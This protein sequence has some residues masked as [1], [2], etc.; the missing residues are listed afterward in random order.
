MALNLSM[1]IALSIWFEMPL[2]LF[3]PRLPH[4]W[5]ELQHFFQLHDFITYFRTQPYLHFWPLCW[6][7]TKNSPTQRKFD[8]GH[9]LEESGNLEK[10]NLQKKLYFLQYFVEQDTFLRSD[11]TYMVL[12]LVLVGW[13]FVHDQK[14]QSLSQCSPPTSWYIIRPN[15]WGFQRL[16]SSSKLRKLEYE[17][18]KFFAETHHCV[19]ENSLECKTN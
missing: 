11:R 1:P 3:G 13:L 7:M 8:P 17:L 6:I 5:A 10:S 19:S 2:L 16:P 14:H 12:T 15:H 9:F 4:L 18:M